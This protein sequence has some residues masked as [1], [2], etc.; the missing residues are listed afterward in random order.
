MT[1]TTS[2]QTYDV[3]VVGGGAAGLSAALVLGRS[4]RSVLVVDGGQP[5]NAPAEGVHGFLTRDGMNPLQLLEVGRHEVRAYGGEIITARV[6]SA[7]RGDDRAAHF[8]VTLDHDG[9]TVTARR[10]LIATGLVDELPPIEGIAERWG[11]DVIHC[12]Y[13]HGWEVCDQ[14]I[15]VLATS[16]MAMHQVVL[17]RQLTSDLVL[18]THTAPPLTDEQLEELAARDIQV[19]PGVVEALEIEDDHLVGVRLQ[20]G[21]VIPRRTLVVAP[22]FVARSELLTRLGLQPANHATGGEF[23]AGIDPSGRTE[24]PGVWVAGDVTDLGATVVT[25]ASEGVL[26]GAMINY[27]LALE[28]TRTALTVRRAQDRHAIDLEKIASQEFWDARYAS[29]ERIWSGNPNAQLVAQVADLPPGR[30]LDIACGE[31]GDAFW[32]AQHGWQVTAVDISQVALDRAAA[33]AGPDSQIDWQQADVLAWQP[34]PA[35]FDLV[36]VHF[37]HLPKPRRDAVYQRLATAVRPGG[38]LL[39]VG[40]HPSDVQPHLGHSERVGLLFTPDE[41]AA[42]LDPTEWQIVV[43]ATPSRAAKDLEGQPMTIHDSVLLALRRSS[44]RAS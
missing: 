37:L 38:H 32:L 4:R 14:P 41:M 16:A 5:R 6:Q 42:L 19:V 26:A 31:G 36:T 7:Q 28:D 20:D 2:Q 40:H 23:I 10:L 22:R 30:A 34:A 12:P 13:C 29:A 27:D 11:H 43:S 21:T 33:M 25:A 44:A 15:G 8:T 18:F 17:F 39:V 9:H 1:E 24:I 35:R 3:V